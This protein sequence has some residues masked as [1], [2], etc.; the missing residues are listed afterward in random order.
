MANR[1]SRRRCDAHQANAAPQTI[2]TSAES[3]A[4]LKDQKKRGGA[5]VSPFMQAMGLVKDHV[6][7][8]VIAARVKQARQAFDSP[9]S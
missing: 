3:I 9:A 8:C 6:P 4:L 1:Q 5:F 7:S 2:S